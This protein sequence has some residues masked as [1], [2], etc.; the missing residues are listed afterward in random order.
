MILFVIC[1]LLAFS[2]SSSFFFFFFVIFFFFLTTGSCKL[3]LI[4]GASR[5]L[6]RALAIEFAKRGHTLAGCARSAEK[7]GELEK[8]LSEDGASTGKKHLFHQVDVV[9]RNCNLVPR[10]SN[11]RRLFNFWLS[12]LRLFFLHLNLLLSLFSDAR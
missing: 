9:C 8:L 5:G 12:N 4:T 11:K 3:V 7:L 2:S 6:G 1:L 10:D